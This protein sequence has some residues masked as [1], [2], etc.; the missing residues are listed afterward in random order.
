MKSSKILLAGLLA[1]GAIVI[2]TMFVKNYLLQSN[3]NLINAHTQAYNGSQT[4][5]PNYSG[6]MMMGNFLRSNNSSTQ[7]IGFTT[8][9]QMLQQT[10]ASAQVDKAKNQVTFTGSQIEITIAAVQ[11]NF[12]DTTFE[13]AGLVNP[14]IIVPAKST[15]TIHLINMD[16]GSSMNH[17]LAITNKTPPYPV[18]S[19]M[20]ASDALIETPILPPR[21]NQDVSTSLYWESSISFPSPDSGSYYYLCQFFNHAN[22]GMY[23][24]LIIL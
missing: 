4:N 13:I 12:P 20:G 15:I 2:S 22:K 9:E 17:G 24:K 1:L 6:G 19:M 8:V 18:F 16:Y 3:P 14:T 11:P 10:T 7:Q 5:G 23:G 21:K